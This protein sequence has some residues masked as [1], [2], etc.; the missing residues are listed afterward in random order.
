MS[1]VRTLAVA[2]QLVHGYLRNINIRSTAC[3]LSTF[4]K[5]V[6]VWH[7]LKAIY[8]YDFKRANL[9]NKVAMTMKIPDLNDDDY[10]TDSS[11]GSEQGEGVP[12]LDERREG[13]FYV[14]SY[15]ILNMSQ[16]CLI[17]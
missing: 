2:E 15:N 11:D 6:L 17:I 8:T 3:D 7:G 1:E 5:L 9:I 4:V 13:I 10:Q 14:I 16:I 12:G